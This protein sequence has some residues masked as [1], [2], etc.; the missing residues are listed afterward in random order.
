MKKYLIVCW[1]LFAAIST[2]AQT[3][4][5]NGNG[6]VAPAAG[7]DWVFHYN[8]ELVV[9]YIDFS[10]LEGEA[11]YLDVR[12]ASDSSLVQRDELIQIPPNVLYELDMQPFGKGTFSVEV[13]T[14]KSVTRHT[15]EVH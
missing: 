13:V 6:T 7:G 11:M 9:V 10:R 14:Y 15:V 12:N 3:V 5:Q 1:A 8:Q 4:A 2:W